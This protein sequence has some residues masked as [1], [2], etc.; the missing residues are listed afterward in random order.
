MQIESCVLESRGHA[1]A[2]SRA[3]DEVGAVVAAFHSEPV[4]TVISG[5]CEA[6]RE[7]RRVEAFGD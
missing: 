6:F 3:F 7:G 4:D 2:V 5:W 1:G